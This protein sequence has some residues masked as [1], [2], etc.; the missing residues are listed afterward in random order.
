MKKNS[1]LYKEHKLRPMSG[2]IVIEALV[3]LAMILLFLFSTLYIDLLALEQNARWRL[4]E[5]E[6]YG[7]QTNRKFFHPKKPAPYRRDIHWFFSP[8]HLGDGPS[9]R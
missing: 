7:L 6:D 9:K 3:V 1:T 4:T 5:R 8:H 2:Q